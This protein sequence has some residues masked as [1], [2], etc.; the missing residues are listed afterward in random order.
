MDKQIVVCSYNGIL[1]SNKNEHSTDMSNHVD[2]L[3]YCDR[4]QSSGFLQWIGIDW[5]EAQESFLR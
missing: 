4:N 1:L 5:K 2:K 3:G